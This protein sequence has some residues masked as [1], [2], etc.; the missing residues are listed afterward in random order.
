[1]EVTRSAVIAELLSY[2]GLLFALVGFPLSWLVITDGAFVLGVVVLM[3]S[4]LLVVVSSFGAVTM[5]IERLG[6]GVFSE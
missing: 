3:A 5:R 2:V 1:M 6:L 4:L